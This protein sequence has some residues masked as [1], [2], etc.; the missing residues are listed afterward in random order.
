MLRNL[1][2]GHLG[3]VTRVVESRAFVLTITAVI[4]LN[5][6]TLGLET[7]A[8]VMAAIGPWLKL[9][10]SAAL[11]IFTVE[12][13]L[14]FI[15]YRGRF[16][17][18]G[19]NLFDLTIV[20]IAWLPA[21]GPLAVLRALR[22]VRVLRLI[23]VVP[24]LRKVVGALLHALPG[25]GSI[26]AVLLLVFYIASVMAT[27]LF[28][29]NFPD[30]FGSIGTSMF[31]LFQ[32]MTLES[33][34]MGIV[35]PVMEVHPNAWLFFVPFIVMTSFTVLNLF[36]ALIVNSM[37]AMQPDALETIHNESVI[38]H[39]EREALSRQIDDLSTEIRALRQRLD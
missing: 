19:W 36:I 34:S 29:A 39:D 24:Q 2:S 18:D 14:K 4:V 10:D 25:M 1:R 11:W 9:F 30:W 21:T 13:T 6:I 8:A 33:W 23:S 37:Q 12:L 22:I 28:G 32:I 35:R 38:A 7:S 17:R 26:I 3:G 5:A 27:N 20:T 16:F 15:A 31:S